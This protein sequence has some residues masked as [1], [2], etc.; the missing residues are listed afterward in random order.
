LNANFQSSSRQQGDWFEATCR[1]ILEAAGFTVDAVHEVIDDAGVEVDIIATD[2]HTIS[3]FIT[4]KGSYRG[5][6][7]GTRRTDTLKKAIA[8]AYALHQRGWGPVLLLTSHLPDTPTG[9]ALLETV[10]P[11]V[12]YDAI[13]VL[14]GERRLRWLAEADERQL[15]ADLDRRKSL[16]TSG[17]P[18]APYRAWPGNRPL[19][20]RPRRRRR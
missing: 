13:S 1:Q 18:P 14:E 2:Q 20:P 6:R 12:L 10:D 5:R 9:R 15:V 7:P 4:C 8:E 16:F 11:D 3:F 17:K 19:H